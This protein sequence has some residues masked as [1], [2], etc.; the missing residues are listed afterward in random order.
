MRIKMI[1]AAALLTM[2]PVLQTAALAQTARPAQLQLT[3]VDEASAP[4]PNATVTIYTIY[5]PRTVNADA[6]GTVVV[7]DLPADRTQVWARTANVSGAE[8]SKL[9]AGANKQTLTVHTTKASESG[10]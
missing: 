10:S 3:I 6:K 9:K 8:T 2:C 7:A 4:V 1:A 5:G